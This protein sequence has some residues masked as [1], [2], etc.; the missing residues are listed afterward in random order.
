MY[1][2]DQE[3]TG[4]NKTDFESL[5]KFAYTKEIDN[6]A[7]TKICPPIETLCLLNKV[8]NEYIYIYVDI[9]PITQ[10]IYIVE[11]PSSNY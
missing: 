1:Y 5:L 8:T 7:Y 11:V 10:Y 4:F 3:I 9:H 2:F 6:T